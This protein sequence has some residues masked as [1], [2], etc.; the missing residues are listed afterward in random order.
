[1]DRMSAATNLVRTVMAMLLGLLLAVRLLSPAGFMPSF[2]HG[3]VAIVACPDAGPAARPMGHHQ[4]GNSGKFHQQCPYAAAAAAAAP[5]DLI[6]LAA[7][8]LLGA[9]LLVPGRAF[10]FL[11][12]RRSGERPPPRAP[13]L[14]A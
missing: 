6:I 10:A 14:P 9:A 3:A 1:M 4:H 11:E 5:V 2:D 7:A 8:T 12:S 13:P